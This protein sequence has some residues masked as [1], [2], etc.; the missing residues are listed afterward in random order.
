MPTDPNGRRVNGTYR[1]LL[2]GGVSLT[3]IMLALWAVAVLTSTWRVETQGE[4]S[5]AARATAIAVISAEHQKIRDDLQLLAVILTY[6]PTDRERIRSAL[7]GQ[8]SPA[9]RVL[10]EAA[11]RQ[12]LERESTR[13]GIP[14]Q[15]DESPDD[16][17]RE[18]R[19]SR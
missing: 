7:L 15:P 13:R 9:V 19:L 12:R 6:E 17:A 11:E 3:S 10:I 8:L 18:R 1:W 2:I 4:T 14:R 5:A 16:R